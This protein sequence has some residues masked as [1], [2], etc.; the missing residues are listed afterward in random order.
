MR[1]FP[2]NGKG[3]AVRLWRRLSTAS[4]AALLAIGSSSQ[5]INLVAQISFAQLEF[6]WIV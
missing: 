2:P 4:K 5:T 3:E 6:K 1:I